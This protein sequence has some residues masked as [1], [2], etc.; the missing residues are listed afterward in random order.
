MFAS[1]LRKLRQQPKE[2]RE[3]LALWG[4]GVVTAAVALVWLYHTPQ[5]VAPVLSEA[6][7][8]GAFS[9]F[10]SA[11]GSQI[12]AVRDAFTAPATNTVATTDSAPESARGGEAATGSAPTLEIDSPA[13]TSGSATVRDDV[14][15]NPSTTTTVRPIRIVT[16]PSSSSVAS[17]SRVAE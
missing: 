13:A 1:V 5:Q 11:A 15:R 3:Q 10:L 2:L 7:D 14:P 4:A 17:S 6:T 8:A 16:V 12:A 9:Q